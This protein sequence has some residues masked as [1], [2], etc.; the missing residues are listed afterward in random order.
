MSCIPLT[1]HGL[2]IMDIPLISN[3]VQSSI[4]AA[5]AEYVAP[6]SLTLDLKD[7]LV[8]DDFKKD[9]SACGI[10]MVKIKKASKFKEGDG[11][12][13]GLK[14]GSSDPYVAVGY[15]KFGK[16]IWSVCLYPKLEP[17]PVNIL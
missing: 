2:N 17:A 14:K 6:K 4:D 7:M 11:S 9:T 15:A 3:F 12:F 8:G 10:L 13:G 1:K 16:S 5:L